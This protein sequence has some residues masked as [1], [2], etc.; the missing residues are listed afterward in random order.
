MLKTSSLFA[1]FSFALLASLSACSSDS[2]GEF[3]TEPAD[4]GLSASYGKQCNRCHGP[5]G[6]GFGRFPRIPGEK[7]SAAAFIAYVREGKGEMPPFSQTQIS[8]ADAE[9]DFTWLTTVRK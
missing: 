4:P 2:D 1:C 3:N 9:K 6:E 7:R 8:D 5:R